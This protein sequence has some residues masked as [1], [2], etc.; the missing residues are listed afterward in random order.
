[1]LYQSICLEQSLELLPAA[2]IDV[3]L[4]LD[5]VD[6]CSQ[7][8]RGVV[9]IHTRQCGVRAQQLPVRSALI[10]AYDGI[11]EDTPVFL[12]RVFE[13]TF[14]LLLFSD[15]A[16]H[17]KLGAPPVKHQLMGNDLDINLPAVFQQMFPSAR[18]LKSDLGP[19]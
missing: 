1:M 8:F 11:L 19:G 15:I 18:M 7:L 12:L 4:M 9:T 2:G 10:N 17:H 6:T 14:R 3:K 5:V 13:S 16:H